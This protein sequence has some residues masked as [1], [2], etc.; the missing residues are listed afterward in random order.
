MSNQR[1]RATHI[2]R[3]LRG[4]QSASERG[5]HVANHDDDVRPLLHEHT[6]E[7]PHNLCRLGCVRSRT[8]AQVYVW[9]WELEIPEEGAGH[10]V[11]V[12]LAG[13]NKNVLNRFG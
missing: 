3:H 10:E 7:P 11:V 12:M 5:I 6:F 2:V 13:V 8:H 1:S 4:H 9:R